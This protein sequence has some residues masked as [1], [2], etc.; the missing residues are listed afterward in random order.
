ME[1]DARSGGSTEIQQ[2][3]TVAGV[4]AAVT[5]A[6]KSTK[7]EAGDRSSET[8]EDEDDLGEFAPG[9]ETTRAAKPKPPD[10]G[11]DAPAAAEGR[12]GPA[13]P[14]KLTRSKSHP[15]NKQARKDKQRSG[16]LERAGQLGLFAGPEYED[17]VW[18]TE[19]TPEQR[20]EAEARR[21]DAAQDRAEKLAAR[22]RE[23]GLDPDAG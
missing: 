17:H 22:L 8:T 9:E 5:P 10:K 2:E 19:P 12:S 3:E 21:A 6:G 18:L 14:S 7:E 11:S 23:L 4:A 16:V 13:A 1:A 20:A 15:S